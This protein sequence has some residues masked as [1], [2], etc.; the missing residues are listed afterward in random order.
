MLG[1][2]GAGPRTCGFA[3]GKVLPRYASHLVIFAVWATLMSVSL[4]KHDYRISLFLS[5]S[6]TVRVSLSEV[7]VL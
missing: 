4:F 6:I 3:L 2:L 7:S 5:P 1:D